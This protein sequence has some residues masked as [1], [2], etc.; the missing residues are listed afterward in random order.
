MA[1]YKES[2]LSRT[3]L[4]RKRCRLCKRVGSDKKIFLVGS[5]VCVYMYVCVACACVYICVSECVCAN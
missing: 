5:L 1:M 2:C 4:K 3:R